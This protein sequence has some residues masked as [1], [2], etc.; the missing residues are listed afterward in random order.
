M[1]NRNLLAV[2][3]TWR[4]RKTSCLVFLTGFIFAGCEQQKI[5]SGLVYRRL[6][7]PN[8][9][10]ADYANAAIE[11]TGGRKGWTRAKRLQFDCVVSLYEPALR[12][13]QGGEQS[14]TD[15]S[16]YLTEHHYEIYP[17]SNSIRVS[18]QEP[19]NKFVWRLSRG[20]FSMPAGNKQNDISPLMGF[21][22]DF[23]EAVLTITTAPVRF[24]DGYITF[25][26]VPTQVKIKGLWYEPI[27]RTTYADDMQLDIIPAKPYWSKVIFYQN[28][29]N[30]LVDTI[31]FS[32]SDKKNFLL[33][34]G[35]DYIR[36][37]K[38]GILVPNKIEIS[39]T[40]ARG[41]FLQHLAEIN[42]K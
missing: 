37:S 12:Q 10:I 41:S 20:Q 2:L 22:R 21:Y 14:R 39:R 5:E 35:Y 32:N 13:A 17:L 19:P 34:R 33:V 15:G 28:K 1:I 8:F 3:R 24:L 6:T 29:E 4:S 25:T 11:A 30:S 26:K 36:V 18:A 38:K 42:F 40:D 23:A 31:W 7:D 27:Q 9:A 16:F